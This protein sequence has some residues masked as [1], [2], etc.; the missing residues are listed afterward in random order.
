MTCIVFAHFNKCIRV[1]FPLLEA[2]MLNLEAGMLN[3]S[4]LFKEWFLRTMGLAGNS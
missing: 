1:Y 4:V 2:G 3:V